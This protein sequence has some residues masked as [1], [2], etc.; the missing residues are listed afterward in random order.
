MYIDESR[1][2]GVNIVWPKVSNIPWPLSLFTRSAKLVTLPYINEIIGTVVEISAN[3]KR[4]FLG[5]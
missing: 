2:G 5:R 1:T 3:H 4:S